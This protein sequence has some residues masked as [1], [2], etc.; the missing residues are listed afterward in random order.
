[1]SNR[2]TP[3]FI[4]QIKLYERKLPTHPPFV[5]DVMASAMRARGRVA[6]GR[7][8]GVQWKYLRDEAQEFDGAPGMPRDFRPAVL[9]LD[10][11]IRWQDT[12][13]GG[14]TGAG[15]RAWINESLNLPDYASI[16][17]LEKQKLQDEIDELEAKVDSHGQSQRSAA[18]EEQL[19]DDYRI[20]EELS[21]SGYLRTGYDLLGTK[22]SGLF[23]GAT[24][25]PAQVRSGFTLEKDESF[26][27][28][29]QRWEA[30]R[31]LFRHTYLIGFGRGLTWYELVIGDDGNKSEFRHFRSMSETQRESLRAQWEAVLDK[32]R[33]AIDDQKLLL[34]WEEEEKAIRAGAKDRDRG[35]RKLT[36]DESARIAQ[37]QQQADALRDSKR[38]L[39]PADEELKRDLENQLFLTT[40]ETFTLIEGARSLLGKPLTLTFRF[41]KSGFVEIA[42]DA[43]QSG[44]GSWLYENKRITGL[45]PPRYQSGLPDQCRILLKSDGGKWA[46]VFGN[47]LHQFIGSSWS[48]PFTIPFAVDPDSVQFEWEGDASFPGCNINAALVL[49]KAATTVAGMPLPAQYQVRVDLISNENVPAAEAGKGTPELYWL[50]LHIPAG[51]CP[52][53]GAPR[54]DSEDPT[55]W[56]NGQV[57]RVQDVTLRC[58]DVRALNCKVLLADAGGTSNLP[59]GLADSVCDVALIDRADDTSANLLSKGLID[60]TEN[61]RVR[62]LDGSN[63]IDALP[64]VGFSRELSVIGCENFLTSEIE[65]RLSGHNKYPNDYLRQVALDGA[66]H[67]DLIL[68]GA[69][70]IGIPKINKAKPGDYPS[71]KPAPGIRYL[72]WMQEIVRSHCPGW[73]LV[74]ESLGLNLV[75]LTGSKA[76]QDRPA[77][78]YNN[79]PAVPIDSPLCLRNELHLRQDTRGYI[80]RVTVIGAVN[81]LTGMRYVATESLPQAHDSRFSDSMYFINREIALT[82]PA[83]ESLT[84]EADCRKRAREEL[85]TRGRPP[86]FGEILIDFDDTLRPNDQIRIF[87][88]KFLVNEVSFGALNGGDGARERLS[89]TVQL[90]EDRR[91]A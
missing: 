43:G 44:K 12:S 81:P 28:G 89:V 10:Y 56:Q 18:E 21:A 78:A 22:A 82:F 33:L 51:E 34:T 37:L 17:A 35:E 20:L 4:P 69:G 86:W 67:P 14:T 32:G 71:C 3:R 64:D 6:P 25:A 7:F 77:L 73:A 91:P 47:P 1:V 38:G 85:F 59:L 72:E 53:W 45:V 48:Q 27:L 31:E 54:W 29:L 70:N 8:T 66:L 36:D 49:L 57:R 60:C 39:T 52:A 58:E 75:R 65:A 79:P 50:E 24:L 26:T 88:I 80:T 87:G 90:N 62:E 9:L 5:F 2:P 16:I 19:A 11:A 42:S 84:S 68:W 40:P 55:N 61:R 83:D 15:G 23:W 13:V 30:P 41:L 76:I 63:G 74:S 46:L